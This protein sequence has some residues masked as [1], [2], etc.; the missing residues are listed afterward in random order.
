MG[1]TRELCA[2]ISAD[3]EFQG[4]LGKVETFLEDKEARE[5]YQN[6]HQQ[7]QELQQKQQ[8]GLKISDSEISSFETTR[9]HL[10]NN[11]VASEF[12]EAQ[13]GLE[14]LQSAVNRYLGLT[15]ESGKVPTQEEMA[16]ASGGGCCGGGCGC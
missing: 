3:P 2:T 4:L 8:A 14:A 6:V 13:Q 5:S 15:L 16:A 12:M 7:G 10:F 9:Q 11:P 1:K